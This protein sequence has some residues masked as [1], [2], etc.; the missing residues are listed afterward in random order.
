MKK[1]VLAI[2]WIL[3]AAA[4]LAA[5]ITGTWTAAVVLDVGSGTATFKF[6]QKGEALTGTYT[7]T[8]GEAKLSGTVKG[9]TVEWSFTN[10]QAGKV[11]Y[12]GKLEGTSKM[13]GTTEYGQL[14]AGTFTAEK[15]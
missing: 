2:S 7:G 10:D 13:K 6:E 1:L 3:A 14:G 11:S 12:K 5:D 9:D 8:L 4:L 15:Q